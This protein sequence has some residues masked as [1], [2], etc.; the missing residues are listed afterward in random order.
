MKTMIKTIGKKYLIPILFFVI[1]IL[2]V[3]IVDWHYGYIFATGDFHYHLDRIEALAS[4]IRSFD[5]LPKVNGY[6]VG[7][8]G[9]ASSLF[10]PDVFLY[11]AAFLKLVGA[12]AVT[13]YLS[14]LVLINFFT[15]FLGYIAGN[16][17]DFSTEKSL[18]FTLMYTLNAY[19]LQTL[20]SRQ[21][22]GELMGMMFF[23]LVLSE[24]LKLKNG[25]TNEWYVLAFAMAGVMCSHTISVFMMVLFSSMFVIINLRVFLNKQRMF[26]ITK[27]ALLTLSISAGIYLPI[28]EQMKNQKYAL[29][30]DPLINIANEVIPIKNLLFNS[31]G[32]QVFHARTVNLG[33]VILLALFIYGF[34]N[35]RHNKNMDITLIALFLFWTCTDLFPWKF[36]DHSIFAMI[37]FP[38]RFF[39]VISL[40]VT[41]LIVN[42]DL[43]IFSKKV[44]KYSVVSFIIFN[45]IALGQ[46]TVIQSQDRLE[47][48]SEFDNVDSYYIGAGH[49]Y[50]PEQVKYSNILNHKK[51]PIEYKSNKMRISNVALNHQS[52]TF[53]FNTYKNVAKVQLPLIYYKGYQSSV[54]GKNVES[55]VPK[56][57]SNGLTEISLKGNGVITIQYRNTFIQIFGAIISLLTVIGLILVQL[58][59][60]KLKFISLPTRIPVLFTRE[61]SNGE[62]LNQILTDINEPN[63]LN[64]KNN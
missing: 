32:N 9:Y 3:G 42:D 37:Q 50:L 13:S 58:E 28:L 52:I 55:T 34:Y 54:Y 57:S 21:D 62:W 18:L 59:F 11:P 23:P 49:E 56:L 61:T 48:Y 1:S 36:F 17:M 20:F 16:R 10:Y 46:Q 38:W 14:T 29:T 39:S 19:R 22:L 53:N 44:I 7:G 45:A 31:L 15:L 33:I 51:R 64:A 8:Y 30:T 24:M 60:R 4:S 41:Y 26:A 40:L 12:S 27:A 63:D 2:I 35:L 5:F 6:F 25:Q 43:H 47:S